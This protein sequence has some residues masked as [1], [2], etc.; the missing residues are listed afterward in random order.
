MF[1]QQAENLVGL[2][3]PRLDE[4]LPRSVQ[5]QHRLLLAVL[6]R[7]K[8]MFGRLTAS[9]IASASAASF[10]LVFTYGFTN[11]GAISLT[12]CP[13]PCSLLAQKWALPQAS[14]PI[15]QGGRL[16]KNGAI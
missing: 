10:L 4:A 2:R 13:R 5:R 15:R 9:Q 7:T 1:G 14:M 8:R 12:V 3:R 11:C 6:D 16:A